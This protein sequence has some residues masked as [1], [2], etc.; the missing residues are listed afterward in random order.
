MKNIILIFI[1]L[2]IFTTCKKEP[3]DLE[4]KFSFAKIKGGTFNI[5][6]KT[7]TIS[8][9]YMQKYLVTNSLW[10]EIMGDYPEGCSDCKDENMAEKISLND[11]SNFIAKINKRYPNI[12]FRLPTANEWEIAFRSGYTDDPLEVR[13]NCYDMKYDLSNYMN[14]WINSRKIIFGIEFPF[15]VINKEYYYKVCILEE[16][17]QQ[18]VC[19]FYT[20]CDQ[21]SNVVFGA[22]I[23]FDNRN[24]CFRLC[25]DVK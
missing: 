25:Y 3:T 5:G 16:L 15:E 7:I 8:D 22:S 12:N 10:K 18:G 6:T 20:S 24:Y 23:D 13:F 14:E 11:A 9:F 4:Q 19:G 21:Y 17:C 2:C 1:G